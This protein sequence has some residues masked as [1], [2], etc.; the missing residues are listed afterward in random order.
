[1][2]DDAVNR[3]ILAKRLKMDGHE[4]STSVSGQGAVE[5]IEENRAFDCILMVRWIHE[6][7]GNLSL[8][9]PS[10]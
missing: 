8:T 10:R 5:L 4:V 9:L 1:M 2:K 7:R 3:N 6:R